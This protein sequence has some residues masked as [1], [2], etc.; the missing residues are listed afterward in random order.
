MSRFSARHSLFFGCAAAI[1]I[2][3]STS[4]ATIPPHLLGVAFEK[5]RSQQLRHRVSAGLRDVSVERLIEQ[6]LERGNVSQLAGQLH[7][8][9]LQLDGSL[10]MSILHISKLYTLD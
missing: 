1:Q 5:A 10:H 4:T 6:L 3:L 7:L 8:F 2:E 9:G